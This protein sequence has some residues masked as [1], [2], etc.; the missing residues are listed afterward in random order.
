MEN[1]AT[2]YFGFVVLTLNIVVVFLSYTICTYFEFIPFEESP[3]YSR[4]QS[5]LQIGITSILMLILVHQLSGHFFPEEFNFFLDVSE[6]ATK[7][8]TLKNLEKKGAKNEIMTYCLLIG[9]LLD[10]LFIFFFEFLTSNNQLPTRSIIISCETGPCFN[11]IAANTLHALAYPLALIAVSFLIFIGYGLIGYF[12]IALMALGAISNIVI[13][14]SINVV[15]SL[16]F[17]AARLNNFLKYNEFAREKVMNASWFPHNYR[18]MLRGSLFLS[19][20]LICFALSGNFICYLNSFNL[21]ILKS[22][23]LFGLLLGFAMPSFLN[24]LIL[25]ATQLLTMNLV[26]L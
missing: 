2:L 13:I 4:N 19:F 9:Y 8:K 20:F 15:G 3:K 10:K 6:D 12:G 5:L 1:K 14:F 21:V 17:N 18:G 7:F 16:G 24:G 25:Q 11:L 22:L 26:I 23:Q